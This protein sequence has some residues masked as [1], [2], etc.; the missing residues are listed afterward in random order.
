M[1]G[2]ANTVI[3]MPHGEIEKMPEFKVNFT[4]YQVLVLVYH[5]CCK[6]LILES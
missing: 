5:H 3:K 6:G 2:G 1:R 4:L